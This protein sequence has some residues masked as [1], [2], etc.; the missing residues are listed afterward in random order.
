MLLEMLEIQSVFT[1]ACQL[2]LALHYFTTH[3]QIRRSVAWAHRPE[4]DRT[5]TGKII[6]ESMLVSGSSELVR[7]GFGPR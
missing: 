3:M 4:H 5:T 6:P 1:D 7:H 2:I